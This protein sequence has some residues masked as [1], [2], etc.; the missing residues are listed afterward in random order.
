MLSKIG[1]WI[2]VIGTS[3]AVAW[4]ADPQIYLAWD[5]SP[6]PVEG[7]AYVI[8]DTDP[9][10]PSVELRTGSQ[11]WRIWSVDPD[12]PGS[13]GDIGVI[14]CPHAQNFGVKILTP[15]GGQ[16]A[17]DVLGVNLQPTSGSNYS[18]IVEGNF[19]S[20]VGNLILQKASG[21]TGGTIGSLT[22]DVVGAATVF[23]VPGGITGDVAINLVDEA[24]TVAIGS[25]A[26][27][28]VT[29]ALGA[30][31]TLSITDVGSFAEVSV[32]QTSGPISIYKMYPQAVV[33]ISKF[34]PTGSLD[35]T[36]MEDGSTL[37][38]SNMNCDSGTSYASVHVADMYGDAGV[39]V[40][41]PG[42][43]TVLEPECGC[44]TSTPKLQVTIDQ[45]SGTADV[46]YIDGLGAQE[47]LEVGGMAGFVE[48]TCT[49]LKGTISLT[50]G[51]AANCTVEVTSADYN[52]TIDLNDEPISGTLT[53][54]NTSY[55]SIINGG[56]V[57]GSV[58]LASSSSGTNYSGSATFGSVSGTIL[59]GKLGVPEDP[60]QII[61]TG[62]L[63]GLIETNGNVTGSIYVHG[64]VAATGVIEVLGS[65]E[66]ASIAVFQD[67]EAGGQVGVF[68]N[69]NGTSNV[70]V[71]GTTRGL[72]H[73]AGTMS[74]QSLVQS[75]GGLASGSMI[76]VNTSGAS[77]S[78][79]A[80]TIWI[81]GSATQNPLPP[82]TMLGAVRVN[83][84]AQSKT[85]NGQV[86]V[87]GCAS[88]SHQDADICLYGT[89]QSSRPILYVDKN[90][91]Y[92]YGT[93]CT[94]GCGS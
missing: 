28:Q 40:F 38:L 85:F 25:L 76:D 91:T 2:V 13:V 52:S 70:G 63:S 18:R 84:P 62:N 7:F 78:T 92:K 64:D 10:F 69:M 59:T 1:I 57:I 30:E 31:A 94:T 36:K 90:C 29:L 19:S 39:N 75:T 16:G 50:Q 60:G 23:D 93:N 12:N 82:V 81:G 58:L 46:N 15:S 34:E 65:L 3:N 22:V 43:L 49:T 14:S 24:A 35:V 77:T 88:G 73:I 37:N 71:V 11:T 44:G 33:T 56:D 9:S 80:G 26:S 79:T 45:M 68:G 66:G 74:A 48:V 54:V 87:V 32:S 67:I 17:R 51:I 55:G 6:P 61:V 86:K 53:L 21:G 42:F 47:H 4:A 20:L 41:C 72:I 89:I 27:N 5:E 8:D 83:C